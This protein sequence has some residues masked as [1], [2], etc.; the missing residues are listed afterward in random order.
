MRF[1]SCDVRVGDRIVWYKKGSAVPQLEVV[2]ITVDHDDMKWTHLCVS[3]PHRPEY[4]GEFYT[5]PG[6]VVRE[7]WETVWGDAEIVSRIGDA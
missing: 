3:N 7:S 1:R 2:I 6:T 5:T 4:V